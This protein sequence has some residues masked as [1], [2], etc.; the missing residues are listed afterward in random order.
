MSV[1]KDNKVTSEHLEAHTITFSELRNALLVGAQHF[2]QS[3]VVSI[4]Y[5]ALFTL[6]GLV[7]YIILESE[8]IAPMSYSLAVGFMLVGPAILVGFF[9]YLM[10]WTR[11]VVRELQI[12]LRGFV[13]HPPGYWACPCCAC[14][15]L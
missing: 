13:K 3:K 12:Y 11:I 6:I 14:F 1:E 15:Y 8:K 10:L 7:L 9:P 4:A 2:G 5:S